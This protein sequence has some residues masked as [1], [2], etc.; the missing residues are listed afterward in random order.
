MFGQRL[1]ELKAR[2]H[3]A[4]GNDRLVIIG[5]INALLLSVREQ[6]GTRSAEPTQTAPQIKETIPGPTP[7]PRIEEGNDHDRPTH[8]GQS[9][10]ILALRWVWSGSFKKP[11]R[12]RPTF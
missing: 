8:R 4:T 3:N 5:E 11:K 9:V 2:L 1:T 7:A 6:R 12:I 10:V